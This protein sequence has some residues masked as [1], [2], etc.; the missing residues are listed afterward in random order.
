MPRTPYLVATRQGAVYRIRLNR[1]RRGNALN[2]G[3]IGAAARALKQLEEDFSVRVVVVEGA[4]PDFCTG[5][6]PVDMGPWPEELSHR[7]PGGSHGPA[8]VPEQELLKTIRHLPKPTIAVLHGSVL[9]EGLDIACVCDIR[10]CADDTVLGDPR[11]LQA[12]FSATGLTYVLPRL[13]GQ[14]QAARILL[15]GEQVDGKE[16]ERIGLVY[17]SFPPKDFQRETEELIRRVA[18]M[19]TRSYAVI[20]EQIL[21]QLDLPYQAALMHSMAVRQTNVIE[22]RSEGA[23]AFIEKRSPEYKGR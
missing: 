15:L 22:D 19:A 1:P 6:D 20:K 3:M 4:G 18:A 23:R 8:P 14:S 13:I 5:D 21:G 17:R 2:Y 9:A 12:R 7:K 11:I 16:A 10:V